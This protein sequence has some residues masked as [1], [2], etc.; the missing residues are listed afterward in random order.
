M[1]SFLPLSVSILAA[2]TSNS[3][4]VDAQDNNNLP[5]PYFAVDFSDP[6]SVAAGVQEITADVLSGPDG[7]VSLRID[8]C[9]K[10]A[11]LPVDIN[12][13]VMPEVTLVLDIY[14]E[15]VAE[16]SRGWPLSSD[17]GGYDRSI[18][19]HDERFYGMGMATG[20]YWPVWG[21]DDNG[22]PPL[23][24][25]IQVV[26]V[27]SQKEDD[28]AP[29]G[30][31]YVNG[32]AAPMQVDL[33]NGEGRTD[34]VVGTNLLGEC[35]HWV[36]S[37]IKEVMVFD[38]PL[39][40]DEVLALSKQAFTNDYEIGDSSNNGDSEGN[41]ILGGILEDVF[42]DNSSNESG[43]DSSSEDNGIFGGILEDIVEDIFEDSSS[44]SSSDESSAHMAVA[45]N[46]VATI[47]LLTT[48]LGL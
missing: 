28:V 1:R 32:R 24:T 11:I 15:S 12:P 31:F 45:I 2:T 29:K 6:D 36:D 14:L 48:L 16:G 25:W 40:S 43:D 21:I 18:V 5:T 9:G 23:K 19:L 46:G 7:I 35:N 30:T 3:V 42:E 33:S 22:Q 37:W 41:G 10:H 26:A 20:D 4:F 39:S 8:E 27:F 34:L 38:Q 44:S 47:L 17:N 13:S